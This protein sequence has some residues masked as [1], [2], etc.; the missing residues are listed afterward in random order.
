MIIVKWLSVHQSRNYMLSDAAVWRGCKFDFSSD[1]GKYDWLVVFDY[2]ERAEKLACPPENTILV[3]TESATVKIYPD[4][5]L[6][7]FGMVICVWLQYLWHCGSC[8]KP[9]CI[10]VCRL[11]LW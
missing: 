7:Q 8:W 10:G 5:Y 3:M 2:A 1:C 6:R 9:N 11:R 4:N